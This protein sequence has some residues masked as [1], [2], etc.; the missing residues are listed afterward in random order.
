MGLI[1]GFGLKEG[2]IAGSI[3]QDSQNLVAV[4]VSDADICAA[5]NSVA[6]MQGGVVLVCGGKKVA[7]NRA[8]YIRHHD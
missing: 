8:S 3:G 7:S 2:A 4:G 5:V 1:R 6:D